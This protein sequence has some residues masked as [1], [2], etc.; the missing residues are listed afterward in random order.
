MLFRSTLTAFSA[1]SVARDLRRGTTPVELL[2]AGG[3]TRNRFLFDQ[4]R[5]RC[6]GMVVRPLS[7]LGIGDLER[8]ALGF[9]LLAWWHGQGHPGSLPSV[10]G[11]RRAAV[12]G[13]RANPP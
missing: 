2:V 6:R 7:E 9:A 5:Q 11:A 10:T 3:G 1:A 8:E 12:L 13:V 4:L